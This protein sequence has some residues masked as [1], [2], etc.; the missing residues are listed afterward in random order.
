MEWVEQ[1]SPSVP[2]HKA[3]PSFVSFWKILPIIDCLL[4]RT[5]RVE[6][7]QIHES[8]TC[9]IFMTWLW[10]ACPTPL[11]AVPAHS[12][13]F[14]WSISVVIANNSILS[15]VA[16]SCKLKWLDSWS[17]IEVELEARSEYPIKPI[18][19][20]SAFWWGVCCHGPCKVAC[21]GH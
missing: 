3:V 13:A 21:V 11:S 6:T 16:T 7:K 14:E 19:W 18:D 10:F 5:S 8:F 17:L 1:A 4:A 15:S 20:L 12:R 2:S 9:S